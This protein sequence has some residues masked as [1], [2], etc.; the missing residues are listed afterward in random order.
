MRGNDNDSFLFSGKREG[1]EAICVISVGR[2]V[3]PQINESAIRLRE[4]C[5]VVVLGSGGDALHGIFYTKREK[6]SAEWHS[7]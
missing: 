6:S 7:Q 3:R 4:N 5:R 2:R 1:T